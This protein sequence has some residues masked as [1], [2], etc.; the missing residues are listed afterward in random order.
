[1]A[2]IAMTGWFFQFIFFVKLSLVKLSQV[3]SS[4]STGEQK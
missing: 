2:M 1:M 4:S 3:K